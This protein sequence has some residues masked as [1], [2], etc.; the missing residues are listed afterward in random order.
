MCVTVCAHVTCL[1]TVSSTHPFVYSD[2]RTETSCSYLSVFG[3]LFK[4]LVVMLARLVLQLLVAEQEGAHTPPKYL[5]SVVLSALPVCVLVTD[6]LIPPSF[7]CV[8][9]L[10][11]RTCWEHQVDD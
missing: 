9:P 3:T 5:P 2:S 7:P 11:M 10:L 8:L 1:Y 4:Y 6:Y